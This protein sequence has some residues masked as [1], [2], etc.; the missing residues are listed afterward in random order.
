MADTSTARGAK[1]VPR[2]WRR[3]RQNT[4]D[5]AGFGPRLWGTLRDPVN[6]PRVSQ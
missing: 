1:Q 6:F 3:I 4:E 5:S 2:F